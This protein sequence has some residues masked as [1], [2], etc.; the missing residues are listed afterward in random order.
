MKSRIDTYLA[1][2]KKMLSKSPQDPPQSA[3]AVLDRLTHP[4]PGSLT[5]EAALPTTVIP[6]QTT[7]PMPADATPTAMPA[8]RLRRRSSG[9][10]VAAGAA[11]LALMAAIVV[12]A[13]MA[14][15]PLGDE[16]AA[17]L[18]SQWGVARVARQTETVVAGR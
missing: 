10:W 3:Q 13:I 1:S 4:Q 11:L 15:A 18:L 7:R 5:A 12:A 9:R 16:A 14:E 6:G 17:S 2:K 8:M